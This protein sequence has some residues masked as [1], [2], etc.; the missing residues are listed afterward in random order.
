MSAALAA[1]PLLAERGI[2]NVLH[3]VATLQKRWGVVADPRLCHALVGGVI[4][5]NSDSN[6]QRNNNTYFQ[7]GCSCRRRAASVRGGHFV[8]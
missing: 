5:E 7:G 3:A 6:G 8:A 2:A 1:A 4:I